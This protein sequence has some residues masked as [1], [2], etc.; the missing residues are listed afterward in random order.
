VLALAFFILPGRS[1]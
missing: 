1:P